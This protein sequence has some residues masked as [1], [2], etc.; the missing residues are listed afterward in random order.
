MRFS[1][2]SSVL[3]LRF[4]APGESLK[5]GA[6]QPS[7]SSFFCSR[8]LPL[9]EKGTS[10]PPEQPSRRTQR[11]LSRFANL[12]RP[13]ERRRSIY[14]QIDRMQIE[15]FESRSMMA[16]DLSV[17]LR[18]ALSVHEN[19]PLSG[20]F[21]GS[22]SPVNIGPESIA[23]YQVLSVDGNPADSRF[24]A[25]QNR[26]V[27]NG[28]F[29]YEAHPWHEVAIRAT[30]I[31]GSTFESNVTV[32]VWDTNDN[33]TSALTLSNDWVIENSTTPIAVG[34]L[35]VRNGNP[36]SAFELVSGVGDTDNA[37]FSIAGNSL[38]LN[39][40]ANAEAQWLYSVRIRA[41]TDAGIVEDTLNVDVRSVNEFAPE[42]L[43][44]FVPWGDSTI[45]I[46]IAENTPV[47]QTV[48]VVR[49]LDS[50]FLDTY[51]YSISGNL[52]QYLRI[53]Q[54]HLIVNAPIDYESIVV[55]DMDL[56]IVATNISTNEVVSYFQGGFGGN[57]S[58]FYPS[59]IDINEPPVLSAIDDQSVA[60]GIESR[61]ELSSPLY[62]DPDANDAFGV[63]VSF[64]INNETPT[65]LTYDANTNE[66]V[67]SEDAPSGVYLVDVTITDSGNLTDTDSF[68]LTI[69][70]SA[71]IDVAGTTGNDIFTVRALGSTPTSPWRISLNGLSLYEGAITRVRS[72]AWLETQAK[73]RSACWRAAVTISLTLITRL[74]ESRTS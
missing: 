43:V 32:T 55:G 61:R 24:S 62:S 17:V 38:S 29:D 34:D 36:A 12:T 56:S 37:S 14:R 57:S 41:T 52:A 2:A 11:F 70:P 68:V 63:N 27:A 10:M 46:Q 60:A 45:F 9:A 8:P 48:A 31:D 22:F 66:L 51:Q 49:A 69:A 5:S 50:D 23:S 21:V 28:S 47:G 1:A 20:M 73:M 67:V 44:P 72:S 53:E 42:R 35:G 6:E 7:F 33:A 64:S 54:N 18:N 15:R 25:E 19:E 3:D 13:S 71:I 16:S 59:I 74:S 30:L 65:W 58:G 26:L 4:F 40:D 39:V